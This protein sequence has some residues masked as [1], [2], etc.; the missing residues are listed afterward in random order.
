VMVS[1]RELTLGKHTMCT[2]RYI[3]RQEVPLRL[4]EQ[5]RSE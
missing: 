2:H 4:R 1:P 5:A 3:S